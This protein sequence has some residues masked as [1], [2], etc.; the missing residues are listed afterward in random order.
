ML[1]FPLPLPPPPP[2]TNQGRPPWLPDLPPPLR[3][4][5]AIHSRTTNAA[6]SSPTRAVF[7][8]AGGAEAW[9]APPLAPEVL[10]QPAPCRPPPPLCCCSLLPLPLRCHFSFLCAALLVPVSMFFHSCQHNPAALFPERPHSC[11]H[12]RWRLPLVCPLQSIHPAQPP[13]GVFI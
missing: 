4:S 3:S 12:Q 13:P 9:P 7:T 8:L 1:S 6:F 11:C 5:A 10:E 2:S